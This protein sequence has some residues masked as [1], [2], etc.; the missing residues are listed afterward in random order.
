[1]VPNDLPEP[2]AKPMALLLIRYLIECVGACPDTRRPREVL[3][4]SQLAIGKPL[5]FTN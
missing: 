4:Q 1:M 5:E 2:R 3:A